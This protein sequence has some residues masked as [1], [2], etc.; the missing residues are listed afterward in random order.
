[1]VVLAAVETAVQSKIY[2]LVVWLLNET[3]WEIR[4]EVL[5]ELKAIHFAFQANPLTKCF[6]E[7][8]T[9]QCRNHNNDQYDCNDKILIDCLYLKGKGESYHSSY[10][11]RIPAYF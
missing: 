4:W 8:S 3:F 2:R 9:H 5:L 11:P 1:V 10:Q 7:T 6:E